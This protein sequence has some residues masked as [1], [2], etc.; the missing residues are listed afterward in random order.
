M[1]KEMTRDQYAFQKFKE[2]IF[3]YW[4][5][6]LR[7]KIFTKN[8]LDRQIKKFW[9][10]DP[11]ANLGGTFKL[12]LQLELVPNDIVL[13]RILAGTGITDEIAKKIENAW[14]SHRVEIKL[15]PKD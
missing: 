12:T 1:D 13:T 8:E 11:T 2:T 4:L 9:D 6:N 15:L 10:A 7:Y 14:L 3:L 5:I